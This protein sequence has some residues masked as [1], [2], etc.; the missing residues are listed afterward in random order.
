MPAMRCAVAACAHCSLL[1]TTI[2]LSACVVGPDAALDWVLDNIRK[3]I[4][5]GKRQS[6]ICF[7]MNQLPLNHQRLQLHTSFWL[8]EVEKMQE[9]GFDEEEMKRGRAAAGTALPGSGMS[10]NRR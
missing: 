6:G 5:D 9:A 4:R 8:E 7:N 3:W 2:L 10:S 1:T